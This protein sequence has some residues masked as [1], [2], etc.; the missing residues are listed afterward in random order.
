MMSDFQ[1]YKA[2]PV[3]REALKAYKRTTMRR[4]RLQAK[5]AVSPLMKG[6][7]WRRVEQLRTMKPAEFRASVHSSTPW[8]TGD[9]GRT[10]T[11]VRA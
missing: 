10:F 6:Y 9:I 2:L 11:R 1:A 3:L 8:M 7:L 5:Q 4:V